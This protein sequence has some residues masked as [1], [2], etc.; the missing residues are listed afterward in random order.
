ML[1]AIGTFHLLTYVLCISTSKQAAI[2]I[3]RDDHPDYAELKKKR[4]K[5]E[6]ELNEFVFINGF[7]WVP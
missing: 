2:L 4:E 1:T 3:L 6:F 7:N 5:K